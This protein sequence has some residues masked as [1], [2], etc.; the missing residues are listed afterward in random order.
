[1]PNLRNSNSIPILT[2][3]LTILYSQTQKDIFNDKMGIPA[4]DTP[5]AMV[6]TPMYETK[7]A[8]KVAVAKFGNPL[9]D[10]SQNDI[11]TIGASH[12]VVRSSPI[13]GPDFDK[14]QALM[15]N[16]ILRGFNSIC[17]KKNL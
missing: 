5:C 2:I 12:M 1:M 6:H 9:I 17:K 10:E 7:K 13:S 16:A 4:L 3:I 14:Q 8:R 15:H 11:F